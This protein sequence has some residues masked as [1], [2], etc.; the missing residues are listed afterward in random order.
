[1]RLRKFDATLKEFFQRR[2]TSLLAE[3]TGGV[4]VVEFLNVELPAVHERRLDLV[5]LLADETLLHIELQSS[6]LAAVS[7]A[8]AA[9]GGLGRNAANKDGEFV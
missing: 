8:N 9:G 2:P 4:Q 7:K 3:L 1:M 5:L 6:N